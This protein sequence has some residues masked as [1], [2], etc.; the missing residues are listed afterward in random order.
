MLYSIISNLS[1]ELCERPRT[2]TLVFF[3]Y[4]RHFSFPLPRTFTFMIFCCVNIWRMSVY[5]D[6]SDFRNL[7]KAAVKLCMHECSTGIQQFKSQRKAIDAICSC[8]KKNQL[9]P[10]FYPIRKTQ[11]SRF[12]T[13]ANTGLATHFKQRF[14]MFLVGAIEAI[15]TQWILSIIVHLAIFLNTVHFIHSL[16][17]G[18]SISRI[19]AGTGAAAT[20]TGDL[21]TWGF[22]T[23]AC[24]NDTWNSKA[25]DS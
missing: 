14:I 17:T 19:A 18:A 12:L 3:L 11:D 4:E 1:V 15:P 9:F 20:L 8:S 23:C 24:R 10:N 2:C 25:A 5:L 16:V 13:N 21:C 6:L 22:P 7:Q